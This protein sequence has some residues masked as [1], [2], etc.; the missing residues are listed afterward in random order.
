MP[1]YDLPTQ[2]R[3]VNTSSSLCIA[4]ALAAALAFASDAGAA[5][6][7]SCKYARIA[8]WNARLQNGELVVDGTINGRKIGIMLD[9]GTE[10]SL[11]L[12]RAASRLGLPVQPLP[13]VKMIGVSGETDVEAAQI[14][15]FRIGE[16]ARSD[17]WV[18]IAGDVDFGRD[19]DFILGEDFFRNVDVEFDLEHGAVRL[20]R[21]K[22]CEGAALA[23]WARDGAGQV[24]IEKITDSNPQIT[25]SV[26]LNGLAMQA[27]LDSGAATSVVN[28]RDAARAGVT[29]K[30]PGVIAIASGRG[31]GEGTIDSWVAPFAS[32]TIG[33]ERIRD[34][35]IRIADLW[36]DAAKADAGQR[37]S[38]SEPQ[39]P[40]MLLGTDF[41]RSH[42]VLVSHS[43][44]RIYF[45]YTGGPVFSIDDP[46]NLPGDAPAKGAGPRAKAATSGE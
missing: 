5:T 21:P 29:P 4:G 38:K 41:L 22:D 44:R 42:R 31:V 28:L 36:K 46:V 45:T 8:E 18:I 35:S 15:E 14:D 17:W 7:G 27:V 32:F 16:A 2:A 39:R 20:F 43:Q 10:R 1:V 9:T 25:F 23:Y 30:S 6:A 24:D 13:G 34:T 40:A 19:A 26:Q 37:G 33:D 3:S 12:R 11:I